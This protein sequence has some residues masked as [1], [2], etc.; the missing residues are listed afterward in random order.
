MKHA[1][2]QIHL[3]LRA[4]VGALKEKNQVSRPG[5]W[6]DGRGRPA[7]RW[8]RS[9]LKSYGLTLRGTEPAKQGRGQGEACSSGHS[10]EARAPGAPR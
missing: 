3:L 9:R 1:H 10:Q 4:A 2:E 8:S 6:K 7:S 5:F